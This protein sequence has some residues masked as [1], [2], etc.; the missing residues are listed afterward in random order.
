MHDWPERVHRRDLGTQEVTRLRTRHVGHHNVVHRAELGQTRINALCDTEE[1]RADD[2]APV[3]QQRHTDR[4]TVFLRNDIRCSDRPQPLHGVR[5][6]RLQSGVDARNLVSCASTRGSVCRHRHQRDQGGLRQLTAVKEELPCHPADQGHGDVVDLDPEVVR[7]LLDVSKVE[8]GEGDLAIG[9][10]TAVEHGPWG[11]ERS[12]HRAA[13]HRAPNGVDH[14]SD[15][16]GQQSDQI[17]RPAR[18]PGQTTDRDPQLGG[19]RRSL[20]QC[21]WRRVG[22]GAAQLRKDVGKGHT[23]GHGVVEHEHDGQH[24][25]LSRPSMTHISHSGRR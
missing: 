24:R 5:D 7:D 18:E 23:V 17:Q 19:G 25:P 22:F 1:Y 10:E 3:L 15:G 8:P 12:R 11:G 2:L 9:G 21:W 14:R 13:G 20:D 4:R 6:L 16:R